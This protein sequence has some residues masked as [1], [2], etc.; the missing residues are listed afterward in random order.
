MEP[1]WPLNIAMESQTK[2]MSA[3]T[4]RKW[5]VVTLIC[6]EETEE[7]KMAKIIERNVYFLIVDFTQLDPYDGQ[8]Y[9]EDKTPQNILL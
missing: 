7:M 6:S 3:D 4:K 1:L 2:T 8:I 9:R 5:N